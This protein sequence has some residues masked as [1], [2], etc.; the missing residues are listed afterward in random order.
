MQTLT[1]YDKNT[2]T[3]LFSP[4]IVM[5]KVQALFKNRALPVF[6]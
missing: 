2:H 5:F 4:R 1:E 3:E 6:I